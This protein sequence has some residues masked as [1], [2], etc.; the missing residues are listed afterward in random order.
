[1]GVPGAAI[2]LADALRISL[3]Q[4][5]GQVTYDLDL[6]GTWW[7]AS[8]FRCKWTGAVPASQVRLCGR[9]DSFGLIIGLGR[10]DGAWPQLAGWF[11]QRAAQVLQQP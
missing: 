2:A 7:V 6:S 11:E 5:A 9:S 3:A 1:L 4:L 10:R 8:G